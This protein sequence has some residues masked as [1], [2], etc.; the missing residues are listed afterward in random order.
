MTSTN[1]I[2]II[3]IWVLR[4]FVGERWI[5]K[6]NRCMSSVCERGQGGRIDLDRFVRSAEVWRMLWLF[7][8]LRHLIV[9]QNGSKPR[10]K[11]N[12]EF[13]K[14]RAQKRSQ[15]SDITSLTVICN[16]QSEKGDEWVMRDDSVTSVTSFNIWVLDLVQLG[17]L[18]DSG[19]RGRTSI[20]SLLSESPVD[21]GI[22]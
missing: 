6:I 13:W 9:V 5:P 1:I 7:S 11:R 10:C 14:K 21:T 4:V 8:K 22:M 20:L 16:Q 3:I 19:R 2:K 18:K 17:M 12:E 15:K